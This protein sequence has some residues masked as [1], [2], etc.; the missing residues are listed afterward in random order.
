MKNTFTRTMLF[1][2]AAMTLG[3]TV[4]SAQFVSSK[5]K[6]EIPFAF[7][8]GDQKF[9]AGSYSA[10]VN[11]S[12]GG[13]RTLF[14]GHPDGSGKR[15]AMST[16]IVSSAPGIATTDPKLVFRCGDSGCSLVQL[17]PGNGP[18]GLIFGSP[19]GSSVGT[20]KLAVIRLQT[21]LAD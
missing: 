13:I 2:A 15:V 3:A 12:I 9:T 16:G 1:A 8:V 6:A 20:Q 14:I 18:G 19:K 21:V 17:W 10:S 11:V 4:A 5:F 7:Q